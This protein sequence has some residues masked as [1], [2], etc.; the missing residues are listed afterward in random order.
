[1]CAAVVTYNRKDVVRECILALQSQTRP[2]DEILIVDNAS[3]DG[4]WEMLQTE[5]PGCQTVRM[6]ENTGASGGFYEGLKWSYDHGFDWTWIIDDEGRATP[7]C[8]EK[9]LVHGC[10]NCVLM[11]VKKDSGGRL[12]GFPVW[13]RRITDAADEVLAR[14]EAVAGDFLFDFTASLVSR[15]IVEQTGFPNRD[16][17]IWFDD[18]EYSF[19]VKMKPDVKI[20]AVP[21]AI[22]LCDFGAGTKKVRFLGR[23][24]YRSEQ[25]AWKTYYGARNMLYTLL[26]TRRKPDE[27][28]LYLLINSRLLL[29]DV[30]YEPDRWERVKMRLM[31]MRDGITGRLGKQVAPR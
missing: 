10:P 2:L 19:R 15:K 1:V 17:F 28:L 6:A 13:R 8:L 25:P 3:T 20:I 11:P 31:G 12:Y 7:D 24:S 4:T 29:M 18:Y 5:F 27:I 14:N 23:E 22:F 26:R 30:A 9:L 16:F 21:D